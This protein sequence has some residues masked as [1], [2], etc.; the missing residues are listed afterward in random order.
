[1]WLRYETVVGSK[2]VAS[3]DGVVGWE[4]GFGCLSERDG[5]A[6]TRVTRVIMPGVAQTAHHSSLT[7]W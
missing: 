6:L 3:Q 4:H 7:T 5:V 1:V 2:N